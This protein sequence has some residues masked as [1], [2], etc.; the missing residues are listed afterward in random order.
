MCLITLDICNYACKDICEELRILKCIELALDC[1]VAISRVAKDVEVFKISLKIVYLQV[2]LL[3][4]FYPFLFDVMKKES[5]D[6]CVQTE[7][8]SGSQIAILVDNC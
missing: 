8:I 3:E 2:C 1:R 4:Q 7:S 6:D 5:K